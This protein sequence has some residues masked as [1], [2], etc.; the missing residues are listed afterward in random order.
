MKLTDKI[1]E[2]FFDQSSASPHQVNPYWPKNQILPQDNHKRDIH[3]MNTE[4][5]YHFLRD[6]THDLVIYIYNDT[7]Y[8]SKKSMTR[9]V[10]AVNYILSESSKRPRIRFGTL[11]CSQNTCYHTL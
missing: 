1:I 8:T 7:D 10:N 6:H 11:D 9:F 2:D 5:I 3:V 4:S